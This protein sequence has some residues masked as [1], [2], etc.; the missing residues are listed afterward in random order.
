M[1]TDDRQQQ[2]GHRDGT[3]TPRSDLLDYDLPEL[4]GA[5]PGVTAP[6]RRELELRTGGRVT[7]VDP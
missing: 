7:G 4:L 2:R 5:A 1:E 6:R 3:G